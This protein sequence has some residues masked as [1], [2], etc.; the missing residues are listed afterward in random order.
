M[1]VELSVSGNGYFQSDGN[2]PPD[3]NERSPADPPEG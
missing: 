1:V 3:V 2:I